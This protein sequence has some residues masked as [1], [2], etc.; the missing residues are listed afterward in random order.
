MHGLK[1]QATSA[2]SKIVTASQ[3]GTH[4]VTLE[5]PDQEDGVGG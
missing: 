3:Q 5:Q 1:P 4:C 2:N